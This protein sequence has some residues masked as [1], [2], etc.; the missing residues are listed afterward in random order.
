MDTD[1]TNNNE[2]IIDTGEIEN[3]ISQYPRQYTTFNPPVKF[4]LILKSNEEIEQLYTEMGFEK[5][6]DHLYDNGYYCS[7]IKYSF[8]E[9]FTEQVTI[10]S[11]EYKKP[12]E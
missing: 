9:P 11:K 6:V 12:N 1:N 7:S 5:F 3:L 4:D 8:I 2:I 10:I